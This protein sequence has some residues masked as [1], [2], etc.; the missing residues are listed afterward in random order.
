MGQ[1]ITHLGV[2]LA[3]VEQ[4]T[5]ERATFAQPADVAPDAAGILVTI[6]INGEVL[7]VFFEQLHALIAGGSGIVLD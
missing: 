2:G 7:Q 4:I 6:D 1:T 5:A 3:A